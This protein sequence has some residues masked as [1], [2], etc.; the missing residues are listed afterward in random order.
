[1]ELRACSRQ[2]HDLIRT[3]LRNAIESI[4]EFGVVWWGES[5]R[6]AVAMKL[7]HQPTFGISRQLETAELF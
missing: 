1:M 5:E 2:D 7:R 4:D 3:I 6:T